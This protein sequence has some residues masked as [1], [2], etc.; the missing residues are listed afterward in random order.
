VEQHLDKK[1]CLTQTRV[2]QLDIVYACVQIIE[3]GYAL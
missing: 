3:N 2:R 1:S